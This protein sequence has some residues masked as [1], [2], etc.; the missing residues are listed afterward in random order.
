ML[1]L[2][3]NTSAD[4]NADLGRD[5]LVAHC[6]LNEGQGTNAADVTGDSPVGTLNGPS[7]T[8]RGSDQALSFNGPSAYPICMGPMPV[9][10]GRAS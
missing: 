1:K 10:R 2:D 3:A 8:A 4:I 7:W 5:R 9:Q 6:P